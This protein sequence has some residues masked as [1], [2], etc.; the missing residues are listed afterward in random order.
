M[1]DEETARMIALLEAPSVTPGHLGRTILSR[2]AAGEYHGAERAELAGHIDDCP[3]CQ[4]R[5]STLEAE[6]R[7]FLVQR[8]TATFL[9]GLEARQPVAWWRRWTPA[10]GGLL[11]AGAAAAWFSL[12]T[13]A[14]PP[15]ALA[16]QTRIKSGVG[17]TFHVRT[18]E[19]V[20]DGQPGGTYHPGDAIQLRYTSPKPGHLVVVSLDARGAVTPFY[21]ADG[22]SLN[23]APGTAEL[24]DG[25]VVL[26]DALGT[27]RIIGCFSETPLSTATVISAGQAALQ[28][29]QGD[30]AAAN[31]LDLDCVQATF[32]IVK[33]GR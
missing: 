17:L 30:P 10:L 18:A 32:T 13:P 26:D 12:V 11:L 21:D 33:Q 19:G 9:A 16:H 15:A 31:T 25:S 3:H 6:R 1:S 22:R 14:V 24:L 8:P 28:A 4:T 23:V 7:A 20:A 2:W 27:E 29:A 5:L